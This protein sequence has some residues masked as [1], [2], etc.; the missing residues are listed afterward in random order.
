M[1]I[2]VQNQPQF[3]VTNPLVRFNH[4]NRFNHKQRCIPIT[5][6]DGLNQNQAAVQNNFN[7]LHHFRLKTITPGLNRMISNHL[8]SRDL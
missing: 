8:L 4:T 1:L 3:P 6:N 5:T 2:S 7:L